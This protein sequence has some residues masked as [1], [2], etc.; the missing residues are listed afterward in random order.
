MMN[1]SRASVF[2]LAGIQVRGFAHRQARKVATLQPQSRAT[3]IG[4]AR[5]CWAGPR[6]PARSPCC[7]S[8]VKSSRSRASSCGS[9]LSK[10]R[11]PAR[12]QRGGVMFALADIQSAVNLESLVH[13]GAPLHHYMAA[14]TT[15]DAGTHVTKRPG[16]VRAGL[17]P[18][19]GQQVPPN[20]AT[21]PPG[22]SMTGQESHTGS[23]DQIPGHRGP[24]KC[25]G[26]KVK[27]LF[28]LFGSS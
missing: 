23:S 17:V 21:T 6:P 5:W 7:C 22:S 26:W 14:V 10:R 2:E 1:A 9:A 4:S 3:A 11:S 13:T 27:A 25:N 20:P 8:V 19:S 18:I 16:P 28:P 24:N 15:P 12:V